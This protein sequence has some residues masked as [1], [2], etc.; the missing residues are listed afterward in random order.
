MSIYNPS[1]HALGL[2]GSR[3]GIF[4]SVFGFQISQRFRMDGIIL[5]TL[6]VWTRIF[7]IRLKEMRFLKYPDMCGW[8]LKRT[9]L[10]ACHYFYLKSGTFS[11]RYTLAALIFYSN[12]ML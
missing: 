3:E 5:Q 6:L 9:N 4:S 12:A 2:W 7:L 1:E 11:V 8:G 10:L